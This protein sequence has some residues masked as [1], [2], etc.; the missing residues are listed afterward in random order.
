MFHANVLPKVQFALSILP[1]FI[2]IEALKLAA[3]FCAEKYTNS[4][5]VCYSF[6]IFTGSLAVLSFIVFALAIATADF[7]GSYEPGLLRKLIRIQSSILII[8]FLLT[9]LNFIM[10]VEISYISGMVYVTEDFQDRV[11]TYK[12][13]H[14]AF[15]AYQMVMMIVA[16]KITVNIKAVENRLSVV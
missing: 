3:N 7:F 1:L 5:G 16:A 8:S 4:G 2:Y 11:L 12:L 15:G 9:V 13:G 14:L 6:V 10:A